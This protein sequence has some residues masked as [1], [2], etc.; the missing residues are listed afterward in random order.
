MQGSAV[1]FSVRQCSSVYGRAVQFLRA[2]VL[3]LVLFWPFIA[4]LLRAKDAQAE[5]HTLE[6][7]VTHQS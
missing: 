3:V 7:L 2:V 4:E 5:P 6:N 1:Q